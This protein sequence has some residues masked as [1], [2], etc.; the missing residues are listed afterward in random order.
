VGDAIGGLALGMATTFWMSSYYP[1]HPRHY[2]IACRIEMKLIETATGKAIASRVHH[3]RPNY[4][5]D[6]PQFDELTKD[7]A[8]GLKRLL[9]QHEVA[10]FREFRPLL[11]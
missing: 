4:S 7:G 11:F 10:A 6:S 5:E 9:Q 3:Q 2:W 1:V 8:P